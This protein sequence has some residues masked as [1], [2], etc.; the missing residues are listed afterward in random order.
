MRSLKYL[1]PED[2]RDSL[3]TNPGFQWLVIV[4]TLVV[5]FFLVTS[6]IDGIK[7]KRLKGKNGRVFEGRVAQILGFIYVLLGIAMPLVAIATKL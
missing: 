7:T 1:I 3:N 4:I 2:V 6:G 5:G